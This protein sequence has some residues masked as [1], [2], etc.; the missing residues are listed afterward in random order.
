MVI[1]AEVRKGRVGRIIHFLVPSR[2]VK[3]QEMNYSLALELDCCQQ[4]GYAGH[5][6]VGNIQSPTPQGLKPLILLPYLFLLPAPN[7][8]SLLGLSP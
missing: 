8:I 2:R 5:Q 1:G 3:E 4:D 7:S 6:I